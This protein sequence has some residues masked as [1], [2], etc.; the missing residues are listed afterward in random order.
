MPFSF[1]EPTIVELDQIEGYVGSRENN[2]YIR[3]IVNAEFMGPESSPMQIRAYAYFAAQPKQLEVARKIEP[4]L[5]FLGRP[6][7]VWPDARANVPASFS[8]E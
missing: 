7:A 5:E 2:E 3:Q 4:F 1:M 6:V 8:E